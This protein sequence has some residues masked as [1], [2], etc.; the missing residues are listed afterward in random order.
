ME[1][2]RVNSFKGQSSVEMLATVSLVLLLLVPVLLLLLVG[3]QVRFEDLSNIQANAAARVIADSINQVYIEG[4]GASKVS[5]VNLPS[6]TVHVSF[7]ENEVTIALQSGNA[8]TEVSYP[9]FG[10]LAGDGVDGKIEGRRGLMPIR[11]HN[12]NGEVRFDYEG[13]E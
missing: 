1:G 13:K 9:F 2:R 7:S 8:L 11:F 3:A 10:K 5:V 6:N 12:E 4:N